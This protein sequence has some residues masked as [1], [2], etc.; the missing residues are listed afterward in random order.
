VIPAHTFV[1]ADD[2]PRLGFVLHGVLGAGHNFRSFIKRLTEVRPEYRFVLIDLRNHGKSTP[3]PPPHTLESA[4]DDLLD[5]AA[6]L[7]RDPD[8]VI[9]HSLGG[10]VALTFARRHVE[11]RELRRP[12]PA[13]H[14]KLDQVWALD[15]DPGPQVAGSSHQVRQVMAALRAHPGPFA[16]RAEVIE[17][18]MNEGLSSGLANWLSTNLERREDKFFWRLE[19]DAIDELLDDY[20]DA[21]L[22]GFLNELAAGSEKLERPLPHVHLLVA[23]NSDRWSGSMKEHALALPA[24][25]NFTLHELADSGH[26]VHVDNPDGLL[27]FLSTHLPSC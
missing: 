26:W 21:D 6:S 19:L 10:K 9:G 8:V 18:I 24:S 12:S 27:E 3:T 20:F 16:T 15:S 13:A 1:G 25:E 4:A 23:E 5:L 7:G 2:A 14:G 22:W 17:R 11:P